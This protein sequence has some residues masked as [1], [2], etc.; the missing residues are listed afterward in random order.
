MII[1]VTVETYQGIIDNVSAYQ[2]L[3]QAK[4]KEKK[5]HKSLNVQD[6]QRREYLSFNCTEFQIHKCEL[7]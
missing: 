7:K 4:R 5:W 3:K 1:Y 6:D 2:T